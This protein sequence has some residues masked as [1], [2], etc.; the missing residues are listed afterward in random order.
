MV[1]NIVKEK[2]L[3]AITH[4]AKI[5]KVNTE[6]V[7]LMIHTKNE[8]L[9]PQFFYLLNGKPKTTEEG[10]TE[11]LDLKTQVLMMKFDPLN[12]VGITHVFFQ[13]Y[14]TQKQHELKTEAKNIYIAIGTN[15]EAKEVQLKIYNQSTFVANVT[16]QEVF[17]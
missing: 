14:F 17:S 13:K 15:N 9:I 4:L 6:N 10:T 1:T 5:N 3:N 7:Q 2:M 16:L 11:Q 12:Y 8:D